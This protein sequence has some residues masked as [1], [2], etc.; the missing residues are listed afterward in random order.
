MPRIKPLLVCTALV[1]LSA[2]GGKDNQLVI[3]GI[4]ATRSACTAVGVPAQTGD[5]TLFSPE[6]SRDASAIDVVAT[7][8]NVQSTCDD[9]GPEILTNATFD[10][11]ATR[12]DPRGAR[13]VV[14]PYYSTVLRAGRV[15]VSKR[16]S[17]VAI[18]FE[19]GQTR[20]TGRGGASAQVNRAAATLPDD[21][22]ERITRK[23]KPGEEDAAIDP[24]ALPEVRDAVSRASFELLI[25]FQ[26]TDAQLRYNATR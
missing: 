19:D 23:R 3:G 2:C 20:A 26:L 13:E 24:M 9:T 15:V 21:I 10:V 1:A 12:T 6:N 4:T 17:H 14:L 5:I 7:I 11:L 25:G 8:T 18:R 22:R 16:V